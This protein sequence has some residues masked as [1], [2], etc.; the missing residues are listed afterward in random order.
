MSLRISLVASRI[1]FLAFR[2]LFFR[3]FSFDC[4]GFAMAA[5]V[6]LDCITRDRPPACTNTLR[7]EDEIEQQGCCVQRSRGVKLRIFGASSAVGASR[8]KAQPPLERLE[9][10]LAADG[11]EHPVN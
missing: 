9:L 11:V 8:Q 4:A 6:S 3:I 1:S 5:P 7:R 10:R 2:T